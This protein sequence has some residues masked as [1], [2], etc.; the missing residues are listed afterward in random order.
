MSEQPAPRSDQTLNDSQLPQ[1]PPPVPV[2]LN[3][4][5]GSDTPHTRYDA[6]ECKVSPPVLERLGRFEVHG[7]IGRGGM[8]AVLRGRDPV[9]GRDLALKVLLHNHHGDAEVLRRFHEEARIGGQLQHPGLVPVHELGADGDRPFFAMKL[10]EGRTLSALL[11]ERAKPA[12]ELPRFLGILE[13]VC[14]A[15]GYAHARGVIHRDLKPV[16]IMVGAFG[17][18][19]VMDWGLAKVIGRLPAMKATVDA[20]QSIRTARSD[21]DGSESRAGSVMGTPAYMP[22]EQARG[23]IEQL[24]RRSDVFGLGAI[25]C[26]ILTGQPPF[27]GR[28]ANEV[29]R[30]A[31]RGDLAEAFARLDGCGADAELVGLEK[32]CLAAEPND[33]P[34]NGA[35]VAARV[36]AYRAG[37][38]ERLRRSDLERAAAE[39]R[40]QEAAA[41]AQ[42]ERRARRLLMGLAAAVLLVVLAGGGGAWLLHQQ[43]ADALARQT[44]TDQQARA[45]VERG[46]ALLEAGWQ[47][48]DLAKLTEAK[49]EGD[50]AVDVAR[51]GG[52]SA[53]VRDQAAALRTDAEER[54]RRAETNRALLASLLDVSAPRE[55]RAYASDE[56]GQMLTLAQPSVDEQYAAA[57]RRW[58]LEVDGQAES[59][60]VARLGAEPEAVV[61]EVIA[62]LDGWILVRRLQKRPEA[63]WRHLL[64]VA[65]QLDRND[66]RR[67]LRALL[68]EGSPP[69]AESVAG[70][71][72]SSP[73]WPALWELARGDKWRRLQEVRR[74]LDPATE[75]VLTVLLL[76]LASNT[77]GDAAGAEEV[78][79]Q[80]LAARPDQVVLLD[81]L[82]RHL[83]QQSPPRLGE[84]IE[85]YRAVRAARPHLG[86]AL[87]K[88]LG[89]ASRAMEGEAVLRDL[90][91]QQPVNPEMHFY[92]GYALKEQGKLDEA[93]A[94]YRKAIDL[95]PDYASAYNNLGLALKEQGKLD[96]SVTALRKA[97]E[98][99]PDLAEAYFNLGLDLQEQGKLEEAVTACRKAIDLKPDYAKAFINL[100]AVLKEQGKLEEAVAACRKAIDLKPDYAEAYS[101]LGAAL[102][103]QGKLDAA[104]TACH[105]AIDLKPDYAFAYNNL[106]AAL[107]EQGKLE[108]AVAACRKAIDL[109]PDYAEAYPNLGSALDMQGKLDA[110]VATCRKAIVLKPGLS[111]AYNVL[112]LALHEQGKV[113][114][115]MAAYREAINLKPGYPYAYSNLGSALSN[116]GKLEEAVAAHRK[117]I[118]LKPD[119]ANPYHNL[120]NALSKQGKHEEAVAAF[121]K[122]IEL[123][124]D[125]ADAYHGLGLALKEQGKLD[126][127]VAALRKAIDLKPDFAWA[128][129]NLGAALAR[130]GK[131]DEAVAAYRKAIDLN[132]VLAEVYYNLGL[133]LKEQGKLDEAV[134]AYRKAIDLKP[135]YAEAYSNLGNALSKQRK[136]D[137]AVT[138]YRKAIDL[139]PDYAEAYSNLGNA[140]SKQRKLDEAVT[141]YRKA[142]DLK[143]D[144][145]EAHGNLGNALHAQNKLDAAV[146]AYRKAIDLKPDLTVV[147]YNLGNA[148]KEQGKLDAAATAYRKAIGLKPDYAEVYTNLGVIL[149]KQG[150]LDEEVAAYR[151]AID[152]KPDLVEANINLGI[153]L[154]QL[155]QFNDALNALTKGSDLLPANDPGRALLRQQLQLCQRLLLLDA[156]LPALL[157]G[158]AKPANAAE[159]IEF[160]QLCMRKKLFAAACR[161]HR[162]A[163]AVD[164]NLTEDV[165]SGVRY[166][167]ACA[168]AL[169][170]C[171]QGKD[172]DKLD[173][174]E[175]AQSRQQAFDWLRADLTWWGQALDKNAAPA[176]VVQ[177]RMRH[178]QTDADFA[179]VRG[180]DDLTKLPEAERAEWQKLWQD[181]E[182]LRKRAAAPK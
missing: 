21:S 77:V 8:G 51:S 158:A 42:A 106:G 154:M 118:D 164:P 95:D 83:E 69:R 52:A 15:I 151:K 107:K 36:A 133:A 80:A 170:G 123:K 6:D 138:A 140:L 41:R 74:A 88:A 167:A 166:D 94:A 3:A 57:F 175:R 131:L 17:E 180:D 152:L 172:T 130:Q 75:P 173:D 111:E 122:A 165:P 91:R 149:G 174:K 34:A 59:D 19:Q 96:E 176:A 116:Q 89:K 129:N 153:A 12:D 156:K 146:A 33:R 121:R 99:K 78:L 55:T 120:G 14:Q 84:A 102:K 30:R 110:A 93:V 38:E 97:I 44:Q 11:K 25:L 49:A 160:G 81:V 112:G 139:K 62:G 35:E 67:Q 100:G 155:A 141:A 98:L 163:F 1:Y 10:V 150:K 61:Q 28:D 64:R 68:V 101:N 147:F 43:R 159:Q 47:A 13:Q 79:R 136:L 124:P 137:E 45:I 162:D 169:A 66:R 134:T 65:E 87:G 108:E 26:E 40:A 128:H 18:V 85:C 168:A 37:V 117:A 71:L 23:E 144:F 82:G 46:R 2:P 39:A 157:K 171:G 5:P 179:G 54:R 181:V 104:V 32:A 31:G 20:E 119:Y 115:A 178:W 114:E 63:E 48:H 113:D 142:I 182:A 127:A 161:F 73:P 109:K 126:A 103:E 4:P 60:V 27:T 16:N 29:L 92:L 105:K 143:P 70:L 177:Q 50:R 24:D 145:A 56:G 7:E 135:D 90:A 148:L 72:G 9:L 76:A 125:Y 86:I 132:P 53:A 58:G 22:P